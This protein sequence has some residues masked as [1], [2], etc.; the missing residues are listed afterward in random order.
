MRLDPFLAQRSEGWRRLSSLLGRL[1]RVGPGSLAV[2]EIEELGR[3]YRRAASDLAYARAQFNDP[4]TVSYLN[5][6]VAR[7]HAVIYAP[8]R[9]RWGK[10]RHFW[11][12]EFPKQV[13]AALNFCL[14][15][16]LC[17]FGS[18]AAAAVVVM[19]SPDSA[20]LLVPEQ[21]ADLIRNR[22]LPGK[23]HEGMPAG[24][25]ALLGSVILTNNIKVGFTAFALGIAFGAGTI[26]VLLTN[27]LMLGA[28]SAILGRGEHALTFWSL[29]APHGGIELLAI[30][31]CGGSG[32][33]MGWALIS[34]GDYS[35]RDALVL[36]ARRAVPLV[37]GVIPIFGIAA[38]VEAF[39]TPAPLPAWL[40]LT[41]GAVGAAAVAAYLTLAGRLSA[42]GRPRREG[43]QG[44]VRPW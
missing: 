24:F 39:V 43:R 37:V 19:I 35:R 28:L 7:G 15:A 8:A 36:A 44:E 3:L 14:L 31:V 38:L 12:D 10:I 42:D 21:F 2:P 20:G 40:K 34:P 32:L 30:C 26:Y 33:L 9:P 41:I 25:E 11:S 23:P 1:A 6:L 22:Q 27:G 13:V 17:L 18:A 4:E 29:L 16:A 5:Q